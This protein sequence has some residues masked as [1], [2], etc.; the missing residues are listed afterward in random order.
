MT[1]F[2]GPSVCGATTKASPTS[3]PEKTYRPERYT[4][5]PPWAMSLVESRA[6]YNQS[7]GSLLPNVDGDQRLKFTQPPKMPHGV[8]ESAITHHAHL[9]PPPQTPPNLYTNMLAQ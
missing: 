1:T 6:R 3:L 8:G 7:L 9:V 2:Q 5:K 4:R